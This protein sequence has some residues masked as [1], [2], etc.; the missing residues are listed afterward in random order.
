MNAIHHILAHPQALWLL[1]ILPPLGVLAWLARRWRR[2]VLMQLS[3]ALGLSL[4]QKIKWRR[5]WRTWGGIAGLILL[6]LGIAGPQWGRDR[7]QSLAPGRDVVVVLDL[8]LSMLAKDVPSA[9]SDSRLGQ[10]LAAAKN[11]ADVAEKRGGHRLALVVFASRAKA[12]CPLTQDYDHFRDALD[13]VDAL[14]PLLEIGPTAETP[15][16][17]RIG[18]G[19]EEAVRL[20]HESAA[21]G[22]QDIVLL[23]D[24]DDPA[25]EEEWRVGAEAARRLKIP[26]HT[27]GLGDPSHA[28]AIPIPGSGD[29]RYHGSIASTRLEEKPLQEIADRTGGSY[30]PARTKA[31]PLADLLYAGRELREDSVPVF[32]QH[33]NWFYAL[34]FAFLAFSFV[35]PEVPRKPKNSEAKN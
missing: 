5:S 1:A 4:L 28:S 25:Q 13:Q 11:L 33:Y 3:G 7:D 17:T 19:L 31:L 26:V 10:A 27:V 9:A 14:D 32:R 12:L 8:S 29:L 2:Q 35:I 22:H 18:R 15:S 16:G 21:A 30:T 20:L 34:S 24:G 23:S 6:V